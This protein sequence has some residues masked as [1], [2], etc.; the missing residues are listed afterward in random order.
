[1]LNSV[2]YGILR[3][4]QLRGG[5]FDPDPENKVTVNGKFGTSNGT[6]DTSKRAKF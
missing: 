6:D 2:T 3:F 5:L 1:M 4:R